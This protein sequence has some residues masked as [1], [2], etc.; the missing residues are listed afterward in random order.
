M[1]SIRR[2]GVVSLMPESLVYEKDGFTVINDERASRPVG[3]AL[4]A[5]MMAGALEALRR[6][7]ARQV[8]PIALNVKP[9]YE[10]YHSGSF[11]L[12]AEAE[13]VQEEMAALAGKNKLDALLIIAEDI[14]IIRDKRGI[15]MVFRAGIESIRTAELRSDLTLTLLDANGNLLVRQPWPAVSIPV[16]KPDGSAWAYQ[17][18]KNIDAPTQARLLSILT[19]VFASTLLQR[20]KLVGL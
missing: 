20:L 9:L 8:V 17:L 1:T 11:V 13:R 4:N 2:V 14:G 10:K 16:E 6:N 12:A 7:G 15:Q 5:A 18:E 19:P 3:D